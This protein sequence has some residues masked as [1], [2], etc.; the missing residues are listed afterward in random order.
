MDKNDPSMH[1]E[2]LL[3]EE[4]DRFSGGPFSANDAILAALQSLN[5]NMTEMGSSLRSL[6]EK[7]ETQTPTM[8]EPATKQKSP[9]TGDNSD[10]EESDADTLLAA[11]KRPKVVTDK[12]NSSTCETS[13]DDESDSLLDDITQSLTD[14]EKTAPKVS[15]KLAKIVNL[16][17]LTK[18]D[19]TNLKEKSDKCLRPIN[20]DRL[21][22]PK[23][24]PEIWGRLDR[25]MTGKD[26]KLSNL[27][28]TLTKVGN[29]TA[30]TTDMLLKARAEDGKVDVDNMV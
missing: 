29:I 12:S 17:W 5:K 8:A 20:C 10:T 25:H 18:L 22:I 9:S 26:L 1:E 3:S 11:N 4:S 24:N 14:M 15:E 23:V 16:R 6:K 19:E 30:Q 21:I 28:T 27:Q 2:A 13:A 7:G